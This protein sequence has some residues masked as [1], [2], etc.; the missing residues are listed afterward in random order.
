[1]SNITNIEELKAN[2]LI[3]PNLILNVKDFYEIKNLFNFLSTDKLYY[4]TI[5]LKNIPHE[6]INVKMKVEGT[7][8]H[9]TDCTLI[10]FPFGFDLSEVSTS[11]YTIQ[12]ISLYH[13]LKLT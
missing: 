4:M 8:S 3:N 1:M 13:Q 12:F 9:V 5:M 10:Y 11:I 2:L 7:S 6:I